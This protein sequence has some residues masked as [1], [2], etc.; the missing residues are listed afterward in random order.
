MNT[1]RDKIIYEIYSYARLRL[2][3]KI[4]NSE[5]RKAEIGIRREVAEK[6]QTK[7]RNKIH[8]FIWRI[9]E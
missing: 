1:V 2:S 6:V 3:E 8:Y 5:K 4:R 9:Y 7:V